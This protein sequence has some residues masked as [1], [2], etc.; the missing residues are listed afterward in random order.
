MGIFTTSFKS[1]VFNSLVENLDISPMRIEN[2]E[3][4]KNSEGG[5]DVRITL[6]EK[7]SVAN[8]KQLVENTFADEKEDPLYVVA[9][10]IKV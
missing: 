8:V 6:L 10:K 9:D 2:V 5:I 7:P 4:E 3:Y 1:A